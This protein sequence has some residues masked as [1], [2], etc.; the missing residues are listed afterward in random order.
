ML[1]NT[2][3]DLTSRERL[4][5]EA[6]LGIAALMFCMPFVLCLAMNAGFLSLA[7]EPLAY[8]YF[9]SQ[10]IFAGDTLAVGVGYL[11]SVLHHIVYAGVHFIPL[12]ASSTLETKLDLFALLTNGCLSALLCLIFLIAARSTS[13]KVIDLGLLALVTL[14]PLYGTVFI[15]FNYAM[16]ADYH[17]LNIVLCVAT[18]LIFQQLWRC[19]KTVGRGVVIL[20]GIF[21]GLAMSNKITMLVLA[22]V[23]LVPA[24]LARDIGC[25][26]MTMRVLLVALSIVITFF[27][28][29]LVS[30]LGS[31]SKMRAGL[32]TWWSFASNPGSEPAFW[33]QIFSGFIVGYNYGYF[34]IFSFVVL[35]LAIAAVLLR[36]EFDRKAGFVTIYCL[37]ASGACLYFIAKRP[38]GS[39]LFES[40]I[41]LFTLSAV[42]FTVFAKWRPARI[43]TTLSCIFWLGFAV[44]TFSF[45]TVYG[46]IA[47]S[48]TDS[49]VKWDA[50]EKVR[51]LARQ[52]PIEVIFPDNSFHH[53]G[54]FELLLKGAADFP[55][56]NINA[57]QK[58]VIDRIIPGM[59][60]RHNFS[61]IKP[62]MEYGDERVLVWFDR[63]GTR[64]LE[65]EYQELAQALS[66][67]GVVRF[68]PEGYSHLIMHIAVIPKQTIKRK[69]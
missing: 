9:Y 63:N 6:V 15:G 34:L 50:F 3:P 27:S 53:E 46:Q 29:H 25:R 8:R 20:L 23:V 43:L 12:V 41:F 1:F 62:E 35:I 40:T 32:Q 16:M 4:G 59:T 60:F 68:V 37:T 13:L 31:V 11:I 66:N 18:L 36:H 48:R 45:P 38:A 51:Q 17:F 30:Y 64:P 2:L 54:P 19:D 56:W 57:G 39:T 14:I 33:D 52:R 58:I 44:A 61:H 26:E 28:V 65:A 24:V 67:P 5:V 21:V 42:L 10:R 55:T 69:L 7:N 22:G 49:S 47:R